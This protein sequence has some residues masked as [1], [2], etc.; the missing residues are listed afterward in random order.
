MWRCLVKENIRVGHVSDIGYGNR[1]RPIV[2]NN[3]H[4]LEEKY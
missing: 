4:K 2:V 1:Q 3:K